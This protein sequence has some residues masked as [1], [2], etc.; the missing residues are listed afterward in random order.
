K[1]AIDPTFRKA[2]ELAAL[3]AEVRDEIAQIRLRRTA[4]VVRVVVDLVRAQRTEE[5]ARAVR[6]DLIGD[7]V[8]GR[9]ER[10]RFECQSADDRDRRERGERQGTSLERR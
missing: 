2:R 4:R 9:R 5:A 1:G 10:M 7:A 6:G 8:V 3:V